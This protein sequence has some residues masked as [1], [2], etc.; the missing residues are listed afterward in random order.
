[1]HTLCVSTVYIGTDTTGW[2]GGEGVGRGVD[3]GGG[4]AVQGASNS[5]R[6]VLLSRNHMKHPVRQ[7]LRLY[8]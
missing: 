8:V 7:N 3:G 4:W 5:G 1:M 6:I 2:M